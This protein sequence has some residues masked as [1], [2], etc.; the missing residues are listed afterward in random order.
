MGPSAGRFSIQLSTYDQFGRLLTSQDLDVVARESGW[1]IGINSLSFDG[2]DI[3]VGIQRSGYDLLADAVCEL[4]VEASGGWKANYIVDVVYSDFAPVVLINDPGE[5]EKDEKITATIQCSVPYDVDDDPSDDTK[6]SYYKPANV[7]A[8]SSNDIGWIVGVGISVFA[9]A[10]IAGFIRPRGQR[11]PPQ[12]SNN[13]KRETPPTTQ[14]KP[15]EMIEEVDDIHLESDETEMQ[16]GD[17]VEDDSS[18]E[19]EAFTDLI[20]VIEEPQPEEPAT[21]SGRLASLRSEMGD[22]GPI[23]K[24]GSIEDRMKQFFGDE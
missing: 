20:E 10:W 6:E 9:V 15:E 19:E 22:D 13:K 11:T 23:E 8:V 5:I 2:G 21:A 14:D 16:T 18:F 1:N 17:S 7:L 24:E 4:T 3:T 12:Q